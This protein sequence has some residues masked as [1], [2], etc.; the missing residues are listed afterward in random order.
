MMKYSIKTNAKYYVYSFLT[1]HCKFMLNL[2]NYGSM[3][4]FNKK[5]LTDLDIKHGNEHIFI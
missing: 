5:F 3:S 1:Q 2:R 4:C